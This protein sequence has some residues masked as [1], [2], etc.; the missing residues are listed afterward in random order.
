MKELIGVVFNGLN[1]VFDKFVPEKLKGYRSVLGLVG[2]AA[3]YVLKAQGI[4]S[5]E[6][7]DAVNT[8]LLVWTGLSLNA[9]KN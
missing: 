4:G 3:V 1:T 9:K 5:V 6:V 7:L 2:L 8:G